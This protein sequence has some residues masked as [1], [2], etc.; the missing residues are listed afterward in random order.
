[1]IEHDYSRDRKVPRNQ[2]CHNADGLLDCENLLPRRRGIKHGSLYPLGLSSE[3]GHRADGIVKLKQGL[4]NGLSS[5]ICDDFG[6]VI[7]VLLDQG[8][9]F[10]K[11]LGSS[12]RTRPAVG[13]K[14]L[15]G[16]LHCSLGIT[17]ISIWGRGPS[18]AGSWICTVFC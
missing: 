18:L 7:F 6:Q 4:R 15:V 5:L 8:T 11:A 12:P 13:H 1:M 3:P 2:S 10:Q 9:P 17:S 14:G 16:G